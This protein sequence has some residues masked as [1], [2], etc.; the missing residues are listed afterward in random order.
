MLAAVH[1]RLWVSDGYNVCFYD[2]TDELAD[3]LCNV[4]WWLPQLHCGSTERN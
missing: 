1:V 2:N 3:A 4:K